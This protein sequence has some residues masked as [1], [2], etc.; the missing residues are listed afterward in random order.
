VTVQT[1][2]RNAIPRAGD[3]VFRSSSVRHAHL[4]DDSENQ[5]Q[6]WHIGDNWFTKWL[7]HVPDGYERGLS[8]RYTTHR[9]IHGRNNQFVYYSKHY[10]AD[11]V[12]RP[13]PK[14]I[15][16]EPIIGSY[17]DPARPPA[18]HFALC[19]VASFVFCTDGG[20]QKT[21]AATKPKVNFGR[22]VSDIARCSPARDLACCPAQGECS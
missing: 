2:T 20:Q 5:Q 9:P 11:R 16:I 10:I 14:K 4:P 21:Q 12:R 19:I 8:Q 15:S 7:L 6:P 22:L 3:I 17:T 18:R 13:A 1:K